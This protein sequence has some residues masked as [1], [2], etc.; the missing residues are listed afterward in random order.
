[1]AENSKIEWT[2]HTFNPWT[3]CTNISPGCDHCYA[4]SWSKRSG[5]VEWGNH[6]RRQT[7][8]AIWNGPVKWNEHA[9]AFKHEHGRRP[10]VFC[11][12]LADVFDNQADP[13]WRTDLFALIKECPRLDWQLLTKRPKNILKMLPADW[14]D[15]YR[16]VWLGIT[17]ENQEWFDRRWSL[18]KKIPA[19][20]KFISYE[21]AIGPL[22]LPEYGP[23][24]DW[25][26]SGGESGPGARPMNPQ[27]A[28]DVIAD[29]RRYGVVPFHKQWGS[30][31]SNPLVVEQGMDFKEAA[32]LD[33]F[34]KGGGLL[35][36]KLVR[37][38]PIRQDSTNRNAA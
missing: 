7:T 23:Y 16:N 37:E 8:E 1:M 38:F 17:A 21:P 27:W 26:I 19:A 25:L 32:A 20:I 22:R 30:Y 35:D 18:L 10:R 6:P 13:E 29:C 36:G 14:G 3:G 31:A 15:G 11:A 28:R 2:D 34:G 4:E 5:I 9:R 24:P 33:K 12:S